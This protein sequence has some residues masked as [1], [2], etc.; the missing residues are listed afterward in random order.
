MGKKI[1][2]WFASILIIN[3]V[4][5]LGEAQN[6]DN[7]NIPS[8]GPAPLSIN[9]KSLKINFLNQEKSLNTQISQFYGYC[10]WDPS[11][12][13]TQGPVYFNP[14]TP[15]MIKQIAPTSSTE[16]ISGGTWVAGKWYGCEFA[17][18]NGQPIIWSIHPVIGTMTEIGNYDPNETGLSF[19]G[20]AYD[21]T[22]G[23]MYGSSSTS[24]YKVNITTGAST[25]IGS[26]N[27][28]GGIMIAITFDG[29]GNL[30]GIDIITDYLYS[31][32]TSTG[33]A[34]K[35]GAGLG[36]DL[37]YAQD[38]AYDI[39]NDILYLSAYTISPVKEGALYTCDTTT[40][41]ATKVGTFQGS[42]EITGLAIPYCGRL[43]INPSTTKGGIF[44]T[45][46]SKIRLSIKNVGGLDCTD[47]SV[48]INVKRG[49]IIPLGNIPTISTITPGE[50]TTITTP[51]LL[52]VGIKPLITITINET[53]CGS[54]DIFNGNARL[55]GLLWSF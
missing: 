55:L 27:I 31:I 24:L 46:Q 8:C 14:D 42:A 17:L 11:T 20:L 51:M 3:M 40:G 43:E 32:D 25:L 4:F 54:T 34:T 15:E 16:F 7:Y 1:I 22:T 18:G 19:N 53:S 48:K 39:D 52:G 30:Y 29:E 49:L 6:I 36:I 41:F 10:T 45:G 37:N 44:K 38:M 23:N 9:Y 47:V 12:T 50:T 33:L 2:I 35:R 28:P 5:P 13:L 26:F 21:V